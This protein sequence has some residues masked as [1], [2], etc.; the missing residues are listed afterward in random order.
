MAASSSSSLF[1]LLL[2]FVFVVSATSRHLGHSALHSYFRT[3]RTGLPPRS[4]Y[5]PIKTYGRNY[6]YVCDSRRF[7]DLGLRVTDFAY[8]NKNLSYEQRVKSLVGS[9]SLEEKVGQISDQARG[10]QRIG[11]PPYSWWSEALHGVSFVGHATYFGDIVPA[12]TSFPTVIVSAASFNES[13]W[14]SIGQASDLTRAMHNLGHAGLTFWSP[15]INVV[16]DPRWGRILET[17]GEDP[18]LVGKYAANFVRGLQDVEGH[19]VAANP[20][21]R[22]LKVSSCCKHYAAYDVDNWFGID[23]YHFDARVAAQDMVETFLLPFEMCVKEGDVSSVMCSYNR[24]NGIPACADP[25]LLSQTLRDDW[26][27]HGYIVSDCDS[28][29]VMH[30]GHKWLGDTP[31]AAVSQTL[32]AGLDLDCGDYYSNF[33]ES[34]VAQGIVRESYID[35]ALKNLYTVLMRL[36]FFDGMPKYE[37]LAEDDICTKDNI[38]LAADAARQGIVLLK[39]DHNILPLRKDKYKKLALV[40]PHTNATEAMIGNY[41]GT[42]CRYV[43]PLDAFSAEGKV[44]YDLG[45]TVWCWEKESHQRAK[46]IAARAD[47]TIIFAGISLEVEAES[48]DR[49]DLFIPYS[50]SN[51]ITEVTE[52]SKG[53]VI[54]VIFSA[55][56]LD[57]SSIAR[58]NAKVSAILWAGYPGAEGGRAIADVV[59]GRYNPGGRLPITWFESEYTKLLPMTSMPLRPIDELGYPGRTYKFFDGQTVYPFGYGL[60][61]TQFKYTLKSVPSSV[62]VKLDPLQLCL[63]LTYMPNASLEE[64]HAGAACQSVNVAD[65]ACNHEIN[66]EVEVANTGKFD[67]NHVVIVYSKPPAGVAGA[68]I[69]QVAAFRRVFV[70]A[71]ASSSVKFSIDACKSLS[72]VEKTAYKVLPRGQHTIVVGD[73]EP[74]VSFPVKVD[75]N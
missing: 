5:G 35:T 69:K 42:P 48:R 44:E 38:E 18:F 19:E 47:A 34:A 7:A 17:P 27:L 55:G 32:R 28:L 6:S 64:E 63:P 71:G 58:D 67:G 43:S 14:K 36:G 62:V 31:E 2:L 40:G 1:L 46:E 39:N 66:F 22:P 53:P 26:K 4:T 41:E 74:T 24:V 61:Y 60:S 15:N 20:D 13:L 12:A 23:R 25:K 45:C 50:Q 10:V 57:I 72:I 16:R 49:D 30:H 29:E 68:P 54:L 33:T 56:G 52:A 59:Y 8:C 37:S 11:L 75:F 9:L 3:H 65:T 73:D 51:F 21:S 70:P